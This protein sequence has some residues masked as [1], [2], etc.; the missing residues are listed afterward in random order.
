MAPR[1]DNEGVHVLVT[2]R[3]PDIK[4]LT[5]LCLKQPDENG[6]FGYYVVA[7]CEG[8][9]LK[10]RSLIKDNSVRRLKDEYA[11]LITDERE[12]DQLDVETIFFCTT[13]APAL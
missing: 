3:A 11:D 9:A 10:W 2:L 13:E 5:A 6:K 7:E 4:E 8:K 12:V 1:K